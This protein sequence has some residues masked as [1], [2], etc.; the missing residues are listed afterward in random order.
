MYQNNKFINKN[1][2][3]YKDLKS[4]GEHA[5]KYDSTSDKKNFLKN[6]T[7]YEQKLVLL[8]SKNPYEVLM[9]LDELDMKNSRLVLSNLTSDEIIK[10]ID[11]FT[12]EN[13]KDFYTKFSDLELVNQFMVYDKNALEHIE[14]LNIE[15]KIGLLNSSDEKT[16]EATYKVYDSL[17]KKEKS[18]VIESVTSADGI[19]ALNEATDYKEDKQEL[20]NEEKINENNETTEKTDKN[21]DEIDKKGE[22]EEAENIAK[23]EEKV[24][25]YEVEE[26]IINEFMMS[27]MDYYKTI[28]PEL[29]DVLEI[30]FAL[31]SDEIKERIINDYEASKSNKK[32]ELEEELPSVDVNE[33][34]LEHEITPKSGEFHTAV[35]NCEQELI[36]SVLE[37]INQY[38][39]ENENKKT[40]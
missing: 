17:G 26:S 14:D 20:E 23:E 8:Q 4:I 33:E 16:L 1:E 38:Q 6:I 19:S 21:K 37:N 5:R 25:I 39:V 29:N 13:K 27:K 2:F 22:T 36:N 28:I 31:L 11:M 7:P 15:R 35:H 32:E 18:V 34:N 3:S 9:Y 12:S 30:S 40:L 10:I 24:E